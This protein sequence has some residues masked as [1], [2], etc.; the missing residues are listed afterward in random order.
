MCLLCMCIGYKDQPR[1]SPGFGGSYTWPDRKQ[2][3]ERCQT[4]PSDVFK[5][6]GDLQIYREKELSISLTKHKT[7][8]ADAILHGQK[9]E[10]VAAE[11]FEKIYNVT[12]ERCGIFVSTVHPQLAASP[13]RVIDNETI[14]E[15]KCPYTA[16]DKVINHTTVPYLKLLDNALVLDPNH[17]YY[18]Q[19]QGQ[20]FCSNRAICYFVV[21]TLKD[22][23][24]VR[25]ARDDIFI[26]DMVKQLL[27]FYRSHFK[28]AILDTFFF[29]KYYSYSFGK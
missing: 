2:T 29:K 20:L 8:R 28:A 16:R 7:L 6:W 25:I 10:T 27:K 23:A 11:T 26:Q 22:I 15:V 12:T 14:V 18:Y 9:Y 4:T 21:Y 17:A 13:D 19:V 1:T 5:I 3:M 24:V